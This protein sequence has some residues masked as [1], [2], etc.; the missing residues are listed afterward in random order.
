MATVKQFGLTQVFS[1]KEP[2]VDIVFVHGLNGNPK[3]TWTHRDSGVFWPAD[4]LPPFLEAKRV[5][6]LTYGYNANV[7]A[8]TDGASKDKIHN[9]AETLVS[10]LAANRSLRECSERP[11]IFVCHS[12]GG[13]VVKRALIYCRSVTNEKIEHLR[14]V[15]VSTYGI[16]FLGTPHN[17]SDVAKWGLLLQ[18]I[19]AAVLPRKFMESSPQLIAALK[20]NNE[21][22][23]NINSLFADIISRFHI[24]FFHETRSTD[25]K[26]IREIIVDESSAAPY[27]DGVERMGIEA[28][29][30]HMCKFQDENAPGFEAVAEAL[31]RY[32]REAPARISE[33]WVDERKVRL[34]ER[35][36]KANEVFTGYLDGA[37]APRGSEIGLSGRISPPPEHVRMITVKDYE[38]E[39]PAERPLPPALQISD[40][41]ASNSPNL[42]LIGISK[43]PSGPPNFI[44]VAPPGFHPNKDFFGME[45]ELAKLTERLL[46]NPKR[47]DRILTA[48]ICGVAG[49]GKSHLA[50]QFAWRFHAEYPGGLFWVDSKSWE[51]IYKSFWDIAQAGA[52]DK[53]K[54]FDD[55]SW[56]APTK[57]V[58]AVRNW[59]QSREYWLLIFDGI[60]FN[61]DE[62]LNHIRRFLPFNKNCTIIY[63]SV[64]ITLQKKHRLFEPYIIRVQPLESKRAREML[65]KHLGIKG[66][67]PDQISKATDL[68]KHYECLPLAIRAIAHRLNATAK[69]IERYGINSH[70]TD[71]KLAEPYLGIMHDLY[72]MR[73][74]EALNLINLLSFFG[75]Y[76]PT[77]LITLGK[78]ALEAWNVPVFKSS[79]PGE[80]G[81]IDTTLGVLIRYGL[82][83]RLNNNDVYNKGSFSSKGTS[84]RSDGE[85]AM[86]PK[87]S[88]SWE[89]SDSF[90]GESSPE[91]SFSSQVQGQNKDS[92]SNAVDVLRL[93]SVVQRFCRDEL[94]IMDE[95]RRLKGF[96]PEANE[97]G[98]Y[99]S[100]IVVATKVVRQSYEN[101]RER[102]DYYQDCGLVTDFREYE[103]QAS[104][105]LELF[106]KRMALKSTSVRD[107]RADLRQ[108]L[109]SVAVQINHMSPSDSPEAARTQKSVFDRSSSSS[110]SLP[111]SSTDEGPSRQL[112]LDW[113]DQASPTVESPDDISLPPHQFNFGPFPPHIYRVSRHRLAHEMGYESDREG[114]GRSRRRAH[115]TFS[116]VSNTSQDTAR[117]RKV[118]SVPSS[119]P[120]GRVGRPTRARIVRARSSKQ[121]IRFPHQIGKT[122][123]SLVKLSSIEGEGRSSR[124]RDTEDTKRPLSVTSEAE[125]ALAAVQLASSPRSGGES[126]H[127]VQPAMPE[128]SPLS[129]PSTPP[130]GPHRLPV[131]LGLQNQSSAE[132][133]QPR[134]SNLQPSST[135]GGPEFKQDLM[136]QSTYSEPGHESANRDAT[137]HQYAAAPLAA[138]TAPS[139]QNHTRHPSAVRPFQAQDMSA[140]M[141]CVRTI[142]SPLPYEEN[143][144]V[145][146]SRHPSST[147]PSP[148]SAIRRPASSPMNPE[149]HPSAIMPG[150]SPP[151]IE[152]ERAKTHVSDPMG[153]PMS[154]DASGRSRASWSTEP[155]RYRAS[156]VL[157]NSQVF[158]GVSQVA[159]QHQA[160]S[161]TGSWIGDV[162][163]ARALQAESLYAAGPPHPAPAPALGPSVDSRFLA[164]DYRFE[165]ELAAAYHPAHLH[166]P[167]LMP[168]SYPSEAI[169]HETILAMQNSYVPQQNDYASVQNDFVSVQNDYG[170]RP[171]SGSSPPRPDY[172]GLGMRLP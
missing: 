18:N 13:L 52:A 104:H 135:L 85:D 101:A 152:Y 160:I 43:A 96:V 126:H 115:R 118:S 140:S 103:T 146:R 97:M 32:S 38:I 39:E 134:G 91:T 112:T 3:D 156:P 151:S 114:R 90:T 169:P 107:A 93:H 49:A 113:T 123:P 74:F 66:A 142:V 12:L 16:L 60:T 117:M 94:T 84:Q 95:E 150:T 154:R 68:V 56:R 136:M 138:R 5:R 10:G 164:Y 109:R 141:P 44:V 110:S 162:H 128:I 165:A 102:I 47:A 148:L 7:T 22:L 86:A 21:T 155:V 80:P 59:L 157:S 143:I 33:R 100:W 99:D 98:F 29:H 111:E 129:N 9:H 72:R 139:S 24:Y 172:H 88:E 166:N 65:F 6:I 1:S 28:D 61:N 50:R 20:T 69:P 92:G 170:L 121:R 64:D 73:H 149:A 62:D 147:G 171:R 79:R 83:L 131:P 108:L 45:K 130:G 167:R 48:V 2:L 54:E 11:I 122:V 63:T 132:S 71:E 120:N 89:M 34:L 124:S 133:L 67:T 37:A 77:A 87:S 31:L 127:L 36:S 82:L 35:Q 137:S 153:E 14:S 161:G 145:T 41:T 144:T 58:D 25:L 159:P 168:Y 30:S 26:G 163:F 46:D 76:V 40:R 106:P 125:K 57:F 17:G 8:F 70:L 158:P 105:I 27:L 23:Q 42:E 75:H 116:I 51:S 4:L 53:A 19:C 78:M 119:P 15:Y 55:P 81:D